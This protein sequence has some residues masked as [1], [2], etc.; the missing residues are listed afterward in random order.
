VGA[1]VGTLL[2]GKV[3][4]MN[5]LEAPENGFEHDWAAIWQTPT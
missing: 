2:A 5:K 4:A 1:F 3:L